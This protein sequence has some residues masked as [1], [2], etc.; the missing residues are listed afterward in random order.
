[1]NG[2]SKNTIYRI[3]ASDEIPR[4]IPLGCRILVWNDKEIQEWM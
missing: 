2:L 4:E 3:I 1:M